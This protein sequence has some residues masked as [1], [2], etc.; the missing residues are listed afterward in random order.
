[1][2]EA[3][4]IFSSHRPETLAFAAPRMDRHDAI[5]LEEPPT[6]GFLAMLEGILSIEDY[7]LAVDMEFPAF[8]QGMCA[9][10]RTLHRKG[11]RIVQVEPFLE[12]LAGIHERFAD[13]GRP[14]DIDP[15]SV[16]FEVYQAEKGATGAL[17]RFYET[18]AAGTFETCV[19]SVKDFAKADAG[20]IRLRDH[21][22]A[23][24]LAPMILDI[25]T[26]YVEAGFIH[27]ALWGALNKILA[28]RAVLK[29][30]YLMGSVVRP[31]LG[32][33]QALGPGDILT[34]LY[35]FHPRLEGRQMDLLAAR[36]LVFAKLLEK[37]EMGI[38]GESYP[39]TKDEVRTIK[40]VE[41]LSL[42][43][44]QRLFPRI[45]LSTTH[46]ARAVV[47]EYLGLRRK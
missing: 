19:A 17:L 24:A 44:C 45:R 14:G 16:E 25:P 38:E 12:V 34:L 3:S 46:T 43:D 2:H 42:N 41:R 8:N 37:S 35:V 27:F 18:V 33:R 7:L 10:L 32:K 15:R 28:G 26:A 39:H 36:S 4:L 29:P 11:K 47:G 9:L 20:R 31:L 6:E 21:L 22:R 1:M 5:F 30:V 40:V 23:E 13:G